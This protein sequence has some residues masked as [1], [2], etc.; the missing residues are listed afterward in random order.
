[1]AA[2]SR[3]G[4][5]TARTIT[6]SPST[7]HDHVIVVSGAKPGAKLQVNQMRL[8]YVHT[9]DQTQCEETSKKKT[10]P[11]GRHLVH[12]SDLYMS[13]R[14]CTIKSRLREH[15]EVNGVHTAG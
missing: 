14:R 8:G 9:V 13:A 15:K 5:E 1:M 10:L 6:H 2:C 12:Y 7:W 11:V 3:S 4:W